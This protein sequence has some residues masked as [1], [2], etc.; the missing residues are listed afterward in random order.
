MLNKNPIGNFA[1]GVFYCLCISM[2]SLSHFVQ[3]EPFATTDQNPFSL[4]NGLPLPVSAALPASDTMSY[5]YAME[6]TNTLNNESN[7]QEN[8]ILDYEAYHLKTGINIGLDNG[9]AFKADLSIIYRGNGTFDQSIDDWHAFF[10]LPGG[11]RAST[12]KNQY[13]IQYINNGNTL[14]D[15]T[16][17]K[18][19]IADLQLS[20]GKQLTS[21]PKL[22]S[23]LWA[24]IDLATGETSNL[25][26][27]EDI[28]VSLYLATNSRLNQSWNVFSN[29]G[30]LVPG[31]SFNPALELA[32][33]VW[34][35]HLGLSWQAFQHIE[36]Q[37]QINA[38]TGF[39]ENSSLRI[40]NGN[41]ELIFG[42]S[43][44]ISP[45]S[46]IDVA[47]SEDIK[48]G[49]APDFSLLINWRSRMGDCRY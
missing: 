15:L 8:I 1:S 14:V 7:A 33:Q 19:G 18:S 11:K 35:G 24:T 29:I 30:L 12:N 9:W 37:A 25:M 40:L 46:D 26:S 31:K 10:N 38:H 17:S 43:V 49:A 39:Y 13:H 32:P 6:I 36:L 34:F 16:Q 41:Y 27:N 5:H 44:R 3:A 23:S 2:L 28:D 22:T 20:L 45:C 47:F 4:I 42:G 48:V 21:Q